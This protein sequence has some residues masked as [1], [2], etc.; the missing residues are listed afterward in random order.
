MDTDSKTD[1]GG[2]R[3][4]NK[5]GDRKSETTDTESD[6]RGTPPETGG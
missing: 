2:K 5:T 1:T 6:E 4:V 3:K